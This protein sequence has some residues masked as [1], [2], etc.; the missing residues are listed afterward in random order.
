MYVESNGYWKDM[1]T[2]VPRSFESVI[3][4]ENLAEEIA[5]DLSNFLKN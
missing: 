1:G 3:L 5:E 2:K 4:D